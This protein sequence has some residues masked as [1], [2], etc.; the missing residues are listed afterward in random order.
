M[1]TEISSVN[2]IESKQF[3][4]N[5]HDLTPHPFVDRDLPVQL[6]MKKHRPALSAVQ[7][8]ANTA[9]HGCQGF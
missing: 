4:I 8:N 1:N 6:L 7:A 5:R 9:P 2:S 3:R